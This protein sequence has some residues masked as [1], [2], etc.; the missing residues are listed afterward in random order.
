MGGSLH[1]RAINRASWS[2]VSFRSYCRLGGRRFS[3]ASTPCSR[4]WRRTR[5]TVGWLTS[6]ASAMAVSTH[7]GP[8]A[9]RSALSKIR[10][11]VSLRA[12]AVPAA[13][14]PFR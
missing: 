5:N 2:P 13:M 3:A 10:A 12:G 7:P 8:S 6:T 9:D 11:W 1:D 14:S 4:Y